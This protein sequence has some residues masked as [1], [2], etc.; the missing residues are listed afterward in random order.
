MRKFWESDAGLQPCDA[1]QTRPRAPHALMSDWKVL[2]A[3]WAVARLPD[4]DLRHGAL[5]GVARARSST[6]IPSLQKGAHPIPLP[7]ARRHSRMNM[8]FR[9]GRHRIKPIKIL[10]VSTTKITIKNKS[11]FLDSRKT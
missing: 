5:R 11:P 1:G 6:P 3:A 7:L 10:C 8:I 4:F 2:L 9:L